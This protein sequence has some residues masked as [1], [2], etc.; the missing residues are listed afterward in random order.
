[1]SLTL[2]DH[3]RRSIAIET[4]SSGSGDRHKFGGSLTDHAIIIRNVS[5]PCQVVFVL[6]TVD[7]RVPISVDGVRF[8]P[9]IHGFQFCS[10]GEEFVYRVLK[11]GEIEV[12][13]HTDEDFD[14]FFP[15]GDYPDHFPELQI[16]LRSEPY[17][18]TK[19]EDALLYQGV[20]GLDDLS[21]SETLRAIEV[22][23]KTWDPYKLERLDHQQDCT[24]TELL[25][26]NGCA[27]FCQTTPSKCCPNPKCT[28][29]VDYV[30]DAYELE[31]SADE[32]PLEIPEK[33]IRVPTL[34]VVA[35]HEDEGARDEELWGGVWV[36]LIFQLCA[37][38]GC[39]VVSNQ[40]T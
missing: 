11:D 40:C 12:I 21:D 29:E 15:Y 30:I 35:I 13:S 33:I 18:S 23:K 28:A 16:A 27:P 14:D 38:C 7:D 1:M 17:D 9:L 36:Q 26:C 20:F 22:A 39:V 6:D 32:P 3:E 25:R 4:V 24:D 8:F 31:L 10:N 19:A 2:F 5:N 34:R 37:E